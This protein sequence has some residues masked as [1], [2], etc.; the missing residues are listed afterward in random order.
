MHEQ[1]GAVARLAE[2]VVDVGRR[3]IRFA[4]GKAIVSVVANVVFE[5]VR[6]PPH[7]LSGPAD[8]TTVAPAA[9]HTESVVARF[10]VAVA[11]APVAVSRAPV[12]VA[13]APVAEAAVPAAASMAKVEVVPVETV[14]PIAPP[15][16]P[17][18]PA[19]TPKPGP[20][21]GGLY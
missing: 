12:A 8:A 9:K 18:L 13:K 10:P 6:E 15:P 4:F 11:H 7:P 20:G 19:E 5:L 14:P 21:S 1:S 2:S 3:I 16:P 17:P